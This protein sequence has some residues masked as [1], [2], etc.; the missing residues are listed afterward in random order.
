VSDFWQMQRAGFRL[1]T[2]VANLT[3]RA[4]AGAARMTRESLERARLNNA[5]AIAAHA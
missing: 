2:G 5:C 1:A 4:M 3:E